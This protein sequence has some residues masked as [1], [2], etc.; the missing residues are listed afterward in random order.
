MLRTYLGP[1]VMTFFIVMFILL[2]QFLWKY[3]DDLVGKGLD[4]SL[5]LELLLYASAGLIPMALPLATL[6]A[7]LMTMGNLGEHNEILAMK[8]AGISLPRILSPLVIL[9]V[10]ITLFAFFCADSVVPVATLKMRALIYSLQQQRPELVIRPGIFFNDVSGYSIR[11][12][13]RERGTNLL[14]DIIIY[15]HSAG[16]GN[17]SVTRADSGY[18]TITPGQSHII[19]E[20][21]S[22]VN[23]EEMDESVFSSPLPDYS[24]RTTRFAS[25][26]M[27]KPLEGF[28]FNRSD[29]ELFEHSFHV[30]NSRQLSYTFDSLSGIIRGLRAEQFGRLQNGGLFRRPAIDSVI[31]MDTLSILPLLDSSAAHHRMS[32]LSEAITAAQEL[33]NQFY[34][35][36][37]DAYYRERETVRYSIEYHRKFSLSLACFILFLIGAPL[38]AIIRKGGL[39]VPVIIS[40]LFFVLYYV[41]SIIGE[42][43][44]REL[45]WTPARGV[46]ISSYILAVVALFLV[47]KATTD[48]VLFSMD[49]Y[50]IKWHQLRRVFGFRG[51]EENKLPTN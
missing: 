48:S 37:N 1:M 10:G 12:G 4:F 41:L 5:I 8:A 27:I 20:L 9:S 13:E 21:F 38:G 31:P 35:Y 33:K 29:E 19:L 51:N 43:F 24:A 26:K 45:I 34:A 18:I 40:V 15:D 25:Q 49:W 7:A 6:L 3:I 50:R 36:S 23:Y 42:K 22:G 39:G 11:V 2:M 44:V 17:V 47:Y 28:A 14:H 46:W 16:R 30:M 32:I